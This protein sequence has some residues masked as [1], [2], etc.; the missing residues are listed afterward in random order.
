M[1]RNSRSQLVFGV[2][3]AHHTPL[4]TRLKHDF[5]Q[6]RICVCRFRY[7]A[8]KRVAVLTVRLACKPYTFMAATISFRDLDN[9]DTDDGGEAC[10]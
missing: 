9:V 3:E 7:E 6:E 5:P 8:S 4:K 10:S 2:A 1:K